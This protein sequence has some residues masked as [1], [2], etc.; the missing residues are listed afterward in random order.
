MVKHGRTKRVIA[1]V[2]ARMFE[3]SAFLLDIIRFPFFKKQHNRFINRVYRDARWLRKYA[4]EQP[5]KYKRIVGRNKLIE[6]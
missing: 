1:K 5:K 3:E 2:G 4:R 6:V